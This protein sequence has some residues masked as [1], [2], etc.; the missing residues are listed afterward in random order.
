MGLKSSSV[1]LGLALSLG[2]VFSAGAQQ[3]SKPEDA[4]KYRKSAFTVMNAQFAQIGAMVQGKVPYD[5]KVAADSAAVVEVMAKL[6]WAAFGEG[7]DKGETKAKS[8]IWT[9]AAKF[10]EAQDKLMTESVKLAAA[11]KTG[12]LDD[13]KTAFAATGGSCKNCHENYRAK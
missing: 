12:K 4:I 1:V 10:K 6:P 8:E 13:L 9:E 5:A 2:A 7:T 11:S 3:F